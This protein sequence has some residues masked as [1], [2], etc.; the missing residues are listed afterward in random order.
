MDLFLDIVTEITLPLVL[1]ILFGTFL[2]RRVGLDVVS[3]NRLVVY[4]TLPSLLVVS[5]AEAELPGYEVEATAVFAVAQFLLLL[6]LGW[7]AAVV[8]RLPRDLRPVLALAAP[9]ANTGN[10]GIPMV[11][12]A[13]GPNL[14]PHQ[15]IITAVLTVL[16]M[17]LAPVLLSAGRA[18]PRESLLAAFRTPLIPAV[19]LGLVL[20]LLDVSLPQVIR[21]PLA[22]VGDANTPAALIALGAQLGAGSWAVSRLA[23]GLGVS[24]RLLLGPL[25]TWLM[26]LAVTMPAELD[27]LFLVGAGAPVGVLLPIFCTEFG[28]HPRFAS[29]MVVVS[30]ALSPLMVTLL[31]YLSRLG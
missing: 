25:V 30:T 17:G 28:R 23:I 7:G 12:L 1:L 14:V 13:F 9:F 10:Y 16:M 3:L 31:V 15:A 8:L 22:L 19:V 26:L 5:L 18:G 27:A 4:G 21:F 11:E 6:A 24:L 2:Q 29:A 20:N